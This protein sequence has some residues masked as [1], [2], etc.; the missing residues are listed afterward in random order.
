MWMI[1]T[2]LALGVEGVAGAQPPPP[3]RPAVAPDPTLAL[4]GQGTTVGPELQAAR[5]SLGATAKKGD[6]NTV[7]LN[8]LANR[9]AAGG[10]GNALVL[11]SG[12]GA[13]LAASAAGGDGLQAVHGD[14]TGATSTAAGPAV[15]VLPA[16]VQDGTASAGAPVHAE[17]VIRG[18]I[19]PAA[20]SCYDNDS[21]PKSRQPGKLVIA[22]KLTPLGETESVSI[23]NNSGLTDS[24]ASCIVAA[25]QNARFAAPGAN[26][27]T[28]R[29]VFAFAGHD[30]QAS[31]GSTRAKAA[32]VVSAPVPR[33]AGE[34]LTAKQDAPAERRR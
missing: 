26:G 14:S 33:P 23:A 27:A 16:G 1:M 2:V 24:V 4:L 17:A 3:A 21:D 12:A 11:P 29:A 25:A 34:V 22:I 20:R 13:P 9:Q 8:D 30:D 15:R 31:A 28:I 18:Q 19:N 32:K 7:D 10:G 5:A 6:K